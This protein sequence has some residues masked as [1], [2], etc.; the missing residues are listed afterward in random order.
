MGTPDFAVPVLDALVEAGHDVLAAYTQPP[1]PAGRG[2]AQRPSPVHSRAEALGIPVHHPASLKSGIEQDRFAAL[3]ADAAVVVAYGLILPPAVLA[4]PR[5]GCLNVHGSLLPRWR[6]AAPIQRA[7]AAGDAQTGITIMQMEQGLDTGPIL[8]RQATPVDRK[9]TGE[10]HDEL[11]AMGAA[12][13]V[14]TLARIDQLEPVAQDDAAACY[15][16]K[17]AKSEAKLDFAR[18]AELLERKVRAF[19]PFPGSWFTLDGERIKLLRAEVVEGNGAPGT[20]LDTRLTLA[21]GT[22][23]LR[24]V[25]LQRAGR[26]AMALDDFLRGRPVAA[27]MVAE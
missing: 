12:L 19:A 3:G 4:A 2:K 24:P 14:Q 7:I 5:H 9:T 10:L 15:A 26:P 21:C 17:I 11:A 25:T 8:L 18:P 16:P 22:D 20:V 27:G 23:A 6:G 13:M 1:R